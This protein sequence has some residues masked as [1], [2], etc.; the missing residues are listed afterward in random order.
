MAKVRRKPKVPP[1]KIDKF[2][3]VNQDADGETGLRLGESPYMRN[4]KITPNLNLKKRP[5]QIDLFGAIGSKIQGMWY[6]KIQ[7]SYHF[8]FACNGNIYEL[9]LTDNTY[10]SIGTLADDLTEF[11]AYSDKVYIMNGNEYYSWDGTTFGTVEG[12]IPEITSATPPAGGIN[13]PEQLLEQKNLLTDWVKQSFS[14]DGTAKEFTLFEGDIQV[15]TVLAKVDGVD[16]TEDTDFTVDRVNGKVTFTVAPSALPDNTIITFK[17]KA[18]TDREQITKCKYSMFY[19]GANDTRVHLWGNPDLPN[20]RIYSQLEDGQP[21][22]EY[23]PVNGFSEIGSDEFSIT[24]I[25]L[26]YSRQI[27]YTNGGTTYYS[28]YENGSFLVYPINDEVG[29]I[30][31]NQVRVIDN[32][33]IS[34]QSKVHKWVATNVRDERNEKTISKRIQ[35]DL[36]GLDL[37]Q[38][39]TFDYE[40]ESEYW[41]CIGSTVYIWNYGND[42]WYVYD[43]IPALNFISIDGVLFYGTADGKIVKFDKDKRN[44]NGSPINCVWEMGFYDF[45]YE[46]LTKYMS[47]AWVS[48]KPDSRTSANISWRTNEDSSKADIRFYYNLATF[49]HANFA[50]YSFNTNYNPQPIH[51]KLKAK[52]FIYFKL[53]VTNNTSD[54]TLILLSINLKTR[55]GSESK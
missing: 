24:D 52:K 8:L 25:V 28:Y 32:T 47:D 43:N 18:T 31:F 29:N 23:F 51:K 6:G 10:V 44:D 9:N 1:T 33:P 27:I 11:F 55:L 41:L 22:A 50:H 21:S 42:T 7:G 48:I 16:K 13:S 36:D 30:P 15:D 3:G 14:G 54:E 4:F 39:I 45:G 5:G 38:A 40:E 37:S 2:Y 35:A 26:Q 20:R 17:M 12:Y 53:I 46:T 49:V 34:I 19:G